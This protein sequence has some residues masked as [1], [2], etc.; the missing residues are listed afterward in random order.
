MEKQ[1]STIKTECQTELLNVIL[2][3]NYAKYAE[4]KEYLDILQDGNMS[5]INEFITLFKDY[6]NYLKA[7]YDNICANNEKNNDAYEKA[8]ADLTEA[9]QILVAFVE[10]ENAEK[11]LAQCDEQKEAIAE[12]ESLLNKINDAYIVKPYYNNYVNA[13]NTK[14]DFENKINTQEQSLPELQSA[15][16]NAESKLKETEPLFENAKKEFTEISSSVNSALKMFEQKEKIEK[17]LESIKEQYIK[18]VDLKTKEEKEIESINILLKKNNEIKENYKNANVEKAQLDNEIKECKSIVDKNENI[19]N[20]QSQIKEL[21]EEC[22][23]KQREFT[24]CQEQY[25]AVNGEYERINNRFLSE[26]AGVLAKELKDGEPCKVC[27]STVHPKP[28]VSNE[29]IEIPTQE[30][31]NNAKRKGI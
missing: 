23:R 24:D 22:T 3:E 11:I 8:S 19:E 27:G 20:V 9:N 6:C 17:E 2:N 10:Y 28:Y 1:I 25:N 21:Q 26:Q 16:K 13:Q 14:K 29:S 12:K 5:I 15:F 18:A 4:L 7:Q 30:E 31:V